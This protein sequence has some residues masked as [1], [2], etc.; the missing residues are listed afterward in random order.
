MMWKIG[1]SPRA[2]FSPQ[3]SSSP[4][5][6]S[7][8]VSSFS[9][10][11]PLPFFRVFILLPSLGYVRSKAREKRKASVDFP[12]SLSLDFPL[13]PSLARQKAQPLPARESERQGLGM[14]FSMRFSIR[15][16][17]VRAWVPQMLP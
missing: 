13:S 10:P 2:L 11:F 1:F 8:W 9:V 5:S 16:Y 15:P 12:L 14:G 7:S 17:Y 3:A 6:P 4:S